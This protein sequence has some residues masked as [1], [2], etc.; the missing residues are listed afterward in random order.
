MTGTEVGVG[1][2]RLQ[3]RKVG[4]HTTDTELRDRALGPGDSRRER[5]AA[6]GQLHQHRIEVRRHLG[7]QRG[8]TVQ[9]DARSLGG[10]VRGDATGVGA[11]PVR[12]VFGGDP[13]LQGGTADLNVFLRESDVGEGLPRR[14]AQLRLHQVDIGDLLGDRVFDLDARIHLDEHV[15]AVF[16]DEEFDGPRTRVADLACEGHR[17]GAQSRPQLRGDV[18][19]R[20]QFDDLLVS[21]LHRAVPFEQVD[22]VAV[23]V[24]QDLHL[25]VSR[26][27][28]GLLEEHRRVPERRFRLARCGLDGLA[29]PGDLADSAHT[30]PAAAGDRFDEH[31]ER[32][33]LRRRHQCVDI[34]GGF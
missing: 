24:G 25:D 6:A 22:D 20:R 16:V 33:R 32:H 31:R 8:A 10:A 19:G 11:K 13:A 14:D 23:G 4:G 29:Q 28:D 9:P 5:A 27:D 12:G 21:A 17:I 1:Q 18:R 3:K 26:L 34:G 7:A 30:A 2:N 15:V